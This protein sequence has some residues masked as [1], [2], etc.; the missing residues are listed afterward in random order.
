MIDV[1]GYYQIKSV[2]ASLL[3]IGLGGV[4]AVVPSLLFI[5][6]VEKVIEFC[7]HQNILAISLLVFSLQFTGYAYLRNIDAVWSYHLKALDTFSI[8][9]VWVTASFITHSSAPRS[10]VATSQSVVVTL[11][12]CVGRGLG[13]LIVYFGLAVFTKDFVL[14]AAAV[15]SII[16]SLFFIIVHYFCL[17]PPPYNRKYDVDNPAS[18]GP[19]GEYKPLKL[20]ERKSEE[21]D[22]EL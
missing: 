3:T 19:S 12:C 9:M 5:Y 13:C 10:L 8:V 18:Q 15:C 20:T 16:A 6:R 4:A 17:K 11:Y 2:G 1:L 7:G 22:D 21:E 14:K